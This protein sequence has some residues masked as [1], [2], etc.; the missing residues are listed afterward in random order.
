[1]RD[2][3][4]FEGFTRAKTSMRRVVKTQNGAISALDGGSFGDI[5]V[6]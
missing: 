1:M 6:V 4:D 2:F 5:Y 3:G